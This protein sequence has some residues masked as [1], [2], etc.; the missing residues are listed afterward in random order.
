MQFYPYS[1]GQVI[2]SGFFFK[3]LFGVF[4]GNIVKYG[5]FPA[6]RDKINNLL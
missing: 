3:N 4:N 1:G 5:V 6:I 2:K